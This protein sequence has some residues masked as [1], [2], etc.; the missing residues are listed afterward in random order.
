MR[1]SFKWS[2]ERDCRRTK[3]RKK[4]KSEAA[5]AAASGL[6]DRAGATRIY[7]L[8]ESRGSDRKKRGIGEENEEEEER[9][10]E[11]EAETDEGKQIDC[12]EKRKK[13]VRY[14]KNGNENT[15][16]STQ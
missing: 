13:G 8:K 3:K 7:Q 6:S 15:R 14:A 5:F 16:A 9:R 4:K 2:S 12:E 10:R 11:S 1:E